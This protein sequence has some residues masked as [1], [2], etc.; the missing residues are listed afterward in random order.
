MAQS[1]VFVRKPREAGFAFYNSI[2]EKLIGVILL[3]QDHPEHLSIQLEPP[4]QPP[5]SAGNVDELEACFLLFDRLFGYGYRRIQ[6]CVDSQDADTRKLVSTRLGFTYEGC[7]CKHQIWKDSSRDSHV[8]SLLNSD[9]KQGARASLFRR[10]YGDA[11]LAADTAQ[12]AK[13]TEYEEQ[14]RV[15]AEQEQTLKKNQ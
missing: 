14:Q 13:A 8:Y 15:L 10:L 2:S 6:C 7:L 12:E 4:I 5:G 3:T 1:F 11:A 9:W